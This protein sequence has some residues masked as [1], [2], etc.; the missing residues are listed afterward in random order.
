[1]KKWIG[2]SLLP[3]LPLLSAGCAGNHAPP[4]VVSPPP[5]PFYVDGGAGSEHGNFVSLPESETTGPGGVHCIIYVWDRPLTAQTALRLRSQ[6][7][8]Q[9]DHPGLYIAN[10]LERIVIPRSSSTL[11]Q[12][13]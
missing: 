2:R 10:E 3:T 6:S 9:P 7:C 11:D 12:M 8:E 5:P 1:M 13:E 4:P